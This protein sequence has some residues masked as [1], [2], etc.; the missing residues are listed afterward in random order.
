MA[1]I[2]EI[3][4]WVDCD[5]DET[6]EENLMQLSEKYMI[7]MQRVRDGQM[8]VTSQFWMICMD[9]IEKQHHFHTTV[10]EG[11]FDGKMCAWEFF[12]P[13]Y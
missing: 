6:I 2:E 4:A 10:Q 11:N 12:L 3:K 1:Y 5:R 9:V 8:G 7:Y 13:F